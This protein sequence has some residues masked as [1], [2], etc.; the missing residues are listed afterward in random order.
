VGIV[1]VEADRLLVVRR[2]AGAYVGAWAVPGG[3]QQRGETMRQAA[4]RETREETGLEMVA[5]DVAWVGDAID[6][7]ADPPRWHYTL[8]D[9]YGRRIG[10]RLQAGDDAAE[11][12]W[13]PL[14]GIRDLPLTP[15]MPSLIDRI[16]QDARRTGG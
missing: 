1:A 12:A 8:V 10:G 14:D 5:G 9:F 16:L 15:T 7:E 4:V 13:V 2:G 11:V 3:R 6:T